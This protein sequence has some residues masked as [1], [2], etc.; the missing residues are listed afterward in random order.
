VLP[1]PS[2][3]GTTTPTEPVRRILSPEDHDLFLKSPTHDL[4]L[5]FTFALSDSCDDTKISALRLSEQPPIIHQLLSLLS[6]ISKLVDSTPPQDQG[7]SRFG[8][9]AFRTFIDAVTQALPTCHE[10]L[11]LPSPIWMPEIST[12]LSHSF[13]SRERIDYGSGHELNFLVYLLT[14]NRLCLLP[15]ATFPAITLIIFP[16][17]IAL[18]RKI[19]STYYLEPAGS[20]GVWGLDDYQFLPFLFGASQ[21]KH[22]PYI[23]PRAVHNEVVVEEEGDEFMYLDMVRYTVGAKSVKGLKW[24]QPML[25]DISGAR[26]WGKL[27]AGMRRI[28]AKE[29]LGKLPIMQHFLFGSLVPAAAGMGDQRKAGLGGDE[30]VLGQSSEHHAGPGHVHRDDAWGDCCGIKIPSTVA[31]GIEARKMG[32]QQGLRPVPFD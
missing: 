15:A 4:I 21:L 9:P 3:I 26:D 32:A 14:L 5:S 25:D 11:K 16:A 27:E 2:D 1:P 20:H 23:T 6:R 28:F 8:N 29:V 7:S 12:Y 19:Q 24:T 13:G 17:Y 18:M 31:A 10:T 22:H 30:D